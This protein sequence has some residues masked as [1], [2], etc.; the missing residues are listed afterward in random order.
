MVLIWPLRTCS[1]SEGFC[2]TSI[3]DAHGDWVGGLSSVVL[4]GLADGREDFLG[5]PLAERQGLRCSGV[6][7]EVIDLGLLEDDNILPQPL[8]VGTYDWKDWPLFS[9]KARENLLELLANAL[10]VSGLGDT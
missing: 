7:Q 2:D 5:D 9:L 1:H 4:A 6:D 10:A 8:P 3:H